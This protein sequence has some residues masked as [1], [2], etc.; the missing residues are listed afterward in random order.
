MLFVIHVYFFVCSNLF[1]R[2]LLDDLDN[3]DV[4]SSTTACWQP[5]TTTDCLL[6]KKINL[7]RNCS[8]AAQLSRNRWHL[9]SRQSHSLHY[10]HVCEV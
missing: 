2:A 5:T 10:T 6:E 4:H 7:L 1:G 8:S 3:T 9:I